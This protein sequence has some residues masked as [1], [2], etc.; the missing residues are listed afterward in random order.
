MSDIDYIETEE[1]QKLIESWDSRVAVL[2][3]HVAGLRKALARFGVGREFFSQYRSFARK[4]HDYNFAIGETE[5]KFDLLSA[6][7]ANEN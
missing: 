4:M 6:E 7:D 5:F 1:Y 3:V 2:E